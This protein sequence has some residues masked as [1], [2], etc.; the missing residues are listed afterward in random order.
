MEAM[1]R[2]VLLVG[3]LR[4]VA[5]RHVKNILRYIL[6]HHKPRTTP[7]AHTLALSDGMEPQAL[8]LTDATTGLQ[9]YYIA[10]LFT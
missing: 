10:W 4:V 9:L 3:R 6:L 7:E 2:E 8:V 5:V 1:H